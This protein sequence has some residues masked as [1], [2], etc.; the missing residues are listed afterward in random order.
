MKTKKSTKFI[1]MLF[2]LLAVII[3][4]CS[5]GNSGTDEGGIDIEPVLRKKAKS[6]NTLNLEDGTW[7]INVAG[8][9]SGVKI[10]SKYTLIVNN[11]E[12]TFTYGDATIVIDLQVML[13]A[14]TYNNFMS[15]QSHNEQISELLEN[16]EITQFLSEGSNISLKG[17]IVTIFSLVPDEILNGPDT[18]VLDLDELSKTANVKTNKDKTQYEI[19]D[20]EVTGVVVYINKVIE[21]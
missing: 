21:K 19:S 17:N 5:T 14:E 1:V 18:E 10:N 13:D 4:G 2:A 16:P 6:E 20:P 11:N 7:D 8:D 12:Y 9:M 3:T 15:L